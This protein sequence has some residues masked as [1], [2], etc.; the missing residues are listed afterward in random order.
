MHRKTSSLLRR[1]VQLAVD[2]VV[3]DA[4]WYTAALVAHDYAL[5]LPLSAAYNKALSAVAATV[6]SLGAAIDYSNCVKRLQLSTKITL[7]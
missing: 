3:S 5:T 7:Y 2:D 1:C 4:S 6:T